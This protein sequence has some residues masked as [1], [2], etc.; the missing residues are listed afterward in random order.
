MLSFWVSI[1]IKYSAIVDRKVKLNKLIF[2]V[3]FYNNESPAKL[4]GIPVYHF[5]TANRKF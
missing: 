4:Q 1:F 5:Q 2:K 3:S